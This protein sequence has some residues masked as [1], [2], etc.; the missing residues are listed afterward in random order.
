MLDNHFDSKLINSEFIGQILRKLPEN[1]NKGSNGTLNVIAGSRNFRGAAALCIGGAMRTGCGIVRLIAEEAV[2]NTVASRHPG[3]TFEVIENKAELRRII[4]EKRNCTAYLIGCGLGQEAGSAA[5]VDL[6]LSY[7]KP[8]VL[9]ADA[10]NIISLST[11][12]KQRLA[13]S[14]ITPHPGEFCRLSGVEMSK[15]KSEPERCALDFSA[16]YGT[17]TVLK[18]YVTY[19]ATPEGKLYTS[20]ASRGLSK[21]GS[22]DVLAGMTAGFFAQNYSAEESA[23]LGVW[24]H[25]EASKLCEKRRGIISMLPEELE[26]FA[27]EVIAGLGY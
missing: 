1:A 27:A 16:K 5:A 8:K 26:L 11:E 7:D 6:V 19:I 12:M 2:V 24:L 15:I 4:S 13:G 14:I 3:C 10:L 17:V 20:Q 23:V 25:A 21:G 22:G 9:D 18:D